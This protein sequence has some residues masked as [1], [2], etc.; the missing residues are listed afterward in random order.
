M[1]TR[2][3]SITASP[4]T[5][6]GSA[7]STRAASRGSAPGGDVKTDQA[8]PA[9]ILRLVFCRLLAALAVLCCAAT[10]WAQSDPG[11]VGPLAV[12]QV[13][14]DYGDTAFTASGFSGPIELR[15]RVHY[16]TTLSGGPF[17][18]LVFL[19]G[20]HATCFQGASAFL[21]WPCSGSHVP[22][23]SYQGYDYVA[24]I[25]ASHGYI[26]VSVSAN[27]INAA[28]ASSGD[29]GMS[30][31]GQLVQRHLDQWNTFNTV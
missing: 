25:L 18:L 24:S 16:P 3:A 7:A 12:T 20:R 27:G 13:E 22:I 15:A 5:S 29:A 2:S 21:E 31:R 11:A 1:G 8:H 4:A 10:A 23:P 6:G 19:P 17:P 9:L 28:D 26:V 30:A 14:Y